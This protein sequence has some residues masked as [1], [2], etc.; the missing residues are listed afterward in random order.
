MAAAENGHGLGPVSVGDMQNEPLVAIKDAP[1]VI[2][3]LH[4]D[5]FAGG[6]VMIAVRCQ[7]E[8]IEQTLMEGRVDAIGAGRLRNARHAKDAE[9][10]P[11]PKVM[12]KHFAVGLAECSV[13]GTVVVQGS[14][15]ISRSGR[16]KSRCQRSRNASREV[17]SSAGR[18]KFDTA[19]CD[20][21]DR[22][23]IDDR[24]IACPAGC[25]DG[26]LLPVE[27]LSDGQNV[28][29]IFVVRPASGDCP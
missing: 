11:V 4:H 18:E 3:N 7:P 20:C 9:L 14:S 25:K 2:V 13:D 27:G 10:L 16:I 29:P 22:A 19:E 6:E 1:T 26:S 28:L 21:R 23:A 17:D 8:R 24:G 12:I 5:R 15:L